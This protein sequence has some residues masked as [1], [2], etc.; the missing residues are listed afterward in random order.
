M[1]IF[2]SFIIVLS[3]LFLANLYDDKDTCLD[4]GFCKEGLT[5]NTDSGQIVINE[6][7]CKKEHGF[8]NNKKRACQF[9]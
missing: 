5:L 8:W 6:T 2:I 9:K 3:I 1:K 7:T 4:T